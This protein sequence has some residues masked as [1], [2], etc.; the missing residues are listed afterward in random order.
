VKRRGGA[1]LLTIF[2]VLVSFFLWMDTSVLLINPDYE[3]YERI[4][5]SAMLGKD[6]ERFFIFVNF[7]FHQIGLSYSGFRS[8][9][10]IFSSTA[11]WLVLSRLQSAQ[12]MNLVSPRAANSFLMFFI[13]AVFLFEYFVIKIRAGFAIGLICCA[14]LC[15]LSPHILRGRIFASVFLVLAF[16]THQYTTAIL[17]VFLGLPF[18]AAI[19]KG[20]PRRKSRWFTFVSV[21]AVAFILYM[22]YSLYELRGEYLFSPMNPVR[23]VMFSIVPLVLLFFTR[24]ESSIIVTGRGGALE[25]FPFYFVRFYIV[26]AMGQLLL[27][28]AGFTEQSGEAQQRLYMLSSV[29]A[30]LSLRLSGPTL[31]APISAYILLMNALFFMR[32]VYLPDFLDYF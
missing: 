7:Y 24:N 22:L 3:A 12:L 21:G 28:V 14:I 6:W 8:F 13:L 1:T 23:V 17:I 29:A 18:V 15:L 16:Y 10:L 20:R 27:F 9:I 19:W 31:R 25:E 11:L 4:Y 2:V 32:S 30:L 26:L 5:Q